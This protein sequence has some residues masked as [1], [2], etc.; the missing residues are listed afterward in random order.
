MER[1]LR[2]HLTPVFSHSLAPW[3]IVLG[4]VGCASI[5]AVVLDATPERMYAAMSEDMDRQGG[6]AGVFGEIRDR[7]SARHAEM[8]RRAEANELV[9]AEDHFYA[10]AILV[11]S[12]NMQ[13]LL[14]AE[15][16]GRKATILGDKRGGPVA[17]EAVDRQAL[18]EGT[19][20]TFGTQYTYSYLTGN[21]QLYIVDPST[22]DA[23]RA[24][25]GLPPLAWFEDRIRQLNNSERS[26][27]L[28]RDL[29]LPPSK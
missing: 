24:A 28:R 26:D 20:Q 27:D 3:L 23:D 6:S 13:H 10:G 22:T 25:V 12:S 2:H 17:A 1:M 16:V 18:I 4:L 29:R 21:W 19:A 7:Q 11:R 9:S 5:P 8:A 14:L 15:S